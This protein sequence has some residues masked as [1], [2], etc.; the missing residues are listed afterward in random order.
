M[1][2]RTLVGTKMLDNFDGQREAVHR[3][4]PSN[5]RL[6]TQKRYPYLGAILNRPGSVLEHKNGQLWAQDD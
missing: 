2:P 6:L 1:R 4:M 5:Y 3:L